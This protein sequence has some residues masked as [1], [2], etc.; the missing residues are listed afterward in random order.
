MELLQIHL[1]TQITL[2]F[3]LNL[4]VLQTLVEELLCAKHCPRHLILQR[5][6]YCNIRVERIINNKLLP[7]IYDSYEDN[8]TLIWTSMCRDRQ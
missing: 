8:R 4:P 5:D 6:S 2:Y 1:I 7:Q 3:S